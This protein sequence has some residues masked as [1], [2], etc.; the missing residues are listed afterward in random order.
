MKRI[1]LI[2]AIVGKTIISGYAQNIDT[3]STLLEELVITENRLQTPF[4]ESA[5]SI[6]VLDAKKLKQ[7]PVQSLPEALNYLPGIDVR[8]RGPVGVQADLSI[9]GSTFEQSLVLINGIKITDPQTGH[10]MLNL[11]VGFE[12]IDEVVV[13]KGPAARIYGQN[14]F[15]GA[16]NIITKIP[17]QRSI[18]LSAFGGDFGTYNGTAAVALPGQKYGQYISFSRNASDGYRENTDYFINNVFYQS[19]LKLASGKFNIQFGYTDREFGANG[20]YSSPSATQQW[21]AVQTSLGSIAYE[22]KINRWTF[23]PRVYWRRNKDQYQFVRGKPEIYENFHTSNTLGAELQ[24]TYESKLGVTGLG[25]ELKNEDIESTN[26]G[27]WNRDNLGVFTEHKFTFGKLLV[28]PGVYF[29]WFSDFGWNAFPGVDASYQILN[30]TRAFASVGRS[31]RI[32]TYTDL[33]YADPANLGNPDLEPESAVSYEAG[34]KYYLKGFYAQVSYFNRITDNQIDWVKNNADDPWQPQNFSEQTTQGVDISAE[35]DFN[36]LLSED[37][38]IQQISLA[39]T[40]IDAQLSERENV[41]SRYVLENLKHQFIGGLNHKIIG[42]FSHQLKS[43][44]IDR[45][46]LPDYWLFDSRVNWHNASDNLDI[47]I[48]ATN[49]FDK[50]YTEVS[51]VPMPGRWFRAGAKFRLDF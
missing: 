15:A 16:I 42:N 26:L 27:N 21:E 48:E 13:L 28:T 23:K 39:Y 14:A 37:A 32:P 1:L 19:E 38:F 31:F 41:I 46:S 36:Y 33:Y 3:T 18:Y 45:V 10:H 24:T 35:W 9:R 30:N 44:F 17:E 12:N 40:Y 8:Q 43:R 22:Q 4:L 34:F 6:E 11:P 2:L 20:F 49:I 7:L 5:R 50:E 47:Y 51:L 25:V 29:N